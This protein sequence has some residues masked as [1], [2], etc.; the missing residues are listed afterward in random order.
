ME[1]ENEARR[2]Q[3]KEKE[4]EKREKEVGG[5]TGKDRREERD[6][7]TKEQGLGYLSTF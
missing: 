1:N 2:R 3:K 4:K 5:R 7:E 6:G